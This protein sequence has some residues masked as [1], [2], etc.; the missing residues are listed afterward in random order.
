MYRIAGFYHK[1]FILEFA[2]LKLVVYLFSCLLCHIIYIVNSVCNVYSR[3]IHQETTRGISSKF[4]W[5]FNSSAAILLMNSKVTIVVYFSKFRHRAKT[6]DLF[7]RKTSHST[8]KGIHTRVNHER[9]GQ[10]G[11]QC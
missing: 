8:T 10:S 9:N 1:E 11:L 5:S 6:H 2:T 3:L 4:K 7:S